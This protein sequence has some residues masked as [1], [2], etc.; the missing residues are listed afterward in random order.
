[1]M[2]RADTD[3]WFGGRAR[4]IKVET[5]KKTLEETPVGTTLL[6]GNMDPEH[7]D[8]E[9]IAAALMRQLADELAAKKIRF[10]VVAL[11][12]KYLLPETRARSETVIAAL[13]AHRVPVLDLLSPLAEMKKTEPERFDAYLPDHM[14]DLGN[15][16]V[17]EQIARALR[18]PATVKG[19]P[20]R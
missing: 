1:M 3:Y 2:R 9:A 8:G 20:T 17:A 7:E 4:T 12:D 15:R 18:D 14:T 13:H 11:A 10:L 16:F 6:T 5:S 19:F